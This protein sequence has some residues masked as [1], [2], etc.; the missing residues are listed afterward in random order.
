MSGGPRPSITTLVARRQ[1][2]LDVGA[3]D[4]GVAGADDL[5]LIL[6]LARLGSYAYSDV[7]TAAYRVHDSN[8]TRNTRM[9]ADAA[10]R[11]LLAHVERAR[12]AGDD[13]EREALVSMRRGSRRYYAEIGWSD[14]RRALGQR[15]VLDAV[16]MLWWSI[17]FCPA[18][19]G[20]VIRDGIRRRLR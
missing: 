12:D 7:V 4:P 8:L 5:D 2:I 15:R 6:K 18:G 14:A 20:Y 1:A 10:D 3:L 11:M 16:G 19:V 17:T 9:M 13:R